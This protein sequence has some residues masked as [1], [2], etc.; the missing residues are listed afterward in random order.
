V[1]AP[2]PLQTTSFP[3]NEVVRR[4]P[5]RFTRAA[6]FHS[7][8]TDAVSPRTTP[9]P[10]PANDAVSLDRD[11]S[12]SLDRDVPSNVPL[13]DGGPLLKIVICRKRRAKPA[14]DDLPVLEEQI[15]V[16]HRG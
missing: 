16:S 1:V 3:W 14:R 13:P 10:P 12:V 5:G 11:E 8:P 6:P 7:P 9:F 4:E 15:D 2:T